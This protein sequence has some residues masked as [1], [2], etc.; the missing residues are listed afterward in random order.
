MYIAF[1]GGNLKCFHVLAIV[2]N[3]A[4]NTDVQISFQDSACNSFGD[5]P[6]SGI[7]GSYGNS[8]FNFLRNLHTVFH[9][10][11]TISHSHYQ[12]TRIPIPPHLCQLSLFSEFVCLLVLFC[13]V[14]YRNHPNACEMISHCGFDL[15][16]H[17]LSVQ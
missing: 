8:M 7:S 1:I 16:V 11:C 13:F 5:I 12:C 14:L 10:D 6:R 2:N 15:H 9:S 4:M 17:V 3:T